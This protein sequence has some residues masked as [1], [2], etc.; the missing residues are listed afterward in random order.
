MDELEGA[1]TELARRLEP[2]VQS[3][4]HGFL[5]GILRAYL[6]QTWVFRSGAESASLT[7]DEAGHA[8]VR[9]NALPKPDVT[10][11]LPRERLKELLVT[12]TPTPGLA[13]ETKVTTHSSKGQAAFGYLRGRL[14]L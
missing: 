6:P 5:G 3:R 1:L 13:S 2:E 8:S 9:P 12:R 7:V 10:V 14:G 11:E 4:L